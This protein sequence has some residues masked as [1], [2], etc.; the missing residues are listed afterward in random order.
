MAA[1]QD[2]MQTIVA[3]LVVGVSTLRVGELGPDRQQLRLA[4]G[5]GFGPQPSHDVAKRCGVE[6]SGGI[7]RK[8]VTWPPLSGPGEGLAER[9][10]GETNATGPRHQLSEKPA[11]L[12]TVELLDDRLRARR[13]PVGYQCHREEDF[14]RVR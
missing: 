7:V 6:P 14:G 12:G 2:E 9:I 11:P 8:S 4:S 1:Q 3:E 13:G 10:F 5:H